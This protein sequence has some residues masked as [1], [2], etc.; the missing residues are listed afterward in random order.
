[1]TAVKIGPG[2]EATKYQLQTSTKMEEDLDDDDDEED[3]AKLMTLGKISTLI[4]GAA[5]SSSSSMSVASIKSSAAPGEQ[6]FLLI[7]DSSFE[8]VCLVGLRPSFDQSI[9][10]VF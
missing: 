7:V 2:F 8:K 6:C 1:M 4:G 9:L 10:A 3:D 5:T